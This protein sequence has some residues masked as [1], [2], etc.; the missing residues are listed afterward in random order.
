[1][2]VLVFVLGMDRFSDDVHMM[3]GR[4]IPGLLR[5]LTAFITPL[6]VLVIII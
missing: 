3:I 5:F 2:I 1:M 4:P 6:I